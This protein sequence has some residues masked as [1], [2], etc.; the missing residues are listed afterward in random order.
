MKVYYAYETM[1]TLLCLLS[2]NITRGA[3]LGQ[4]QGRVAE[5]TKIDATTWVNI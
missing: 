3:K 4:I 1:C 2:I 5:A